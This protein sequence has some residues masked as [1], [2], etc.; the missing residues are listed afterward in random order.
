MDNIKLMLMEA[1]INGY[2]E[3][4]KDSSKAEKEEKES[5]DD[6]ISRQWLMGCVNEGW[7]KFDTEKDK[8]IF[9]HLIRD[10]APPVTSQSKYEDVAKAFQFGMALGFAAK[11]DEMDEIIEGVKKA[12][13][14]SEEEN[15]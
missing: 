2:T 7:I 12:V 11:Y 1:N 4:L 3:G 5:C 8:N 9:I 13:K 10:I 15:G 14:E 6:V